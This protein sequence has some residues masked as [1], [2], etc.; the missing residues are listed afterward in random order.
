MDRIKEIDDRVGAL[1]SEILD[2]VI[3]EPD[4]DKVTAIVLAK[5]SEI[6][7]LAVERAYW[8]ARRLSARDWTK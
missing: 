7:K 6:E 3:N 8:K 4:L 1:K 2:A 5:I